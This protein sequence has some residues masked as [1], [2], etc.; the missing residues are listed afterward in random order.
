MASG[1]PP[2]CS[3]AH[4]KLSRPAPP[5]AGSCP[6]ALPA[7]GFFSFVAIASRFLA[8]PVLLFFSK[9]AKRMLR[10]CSKRGGVYWWSQSQDEATGELSAKPDRTAGARQ[11]RL[12][13]ARCSASRRLRVGP[14]AHDR[15]D[16]R[17]RVRPR[18]R[19]PSS[20]AADSPPLPSGGRRAHAHKSRGSCRVRGG[21]AR[22]RLRF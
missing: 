18:T 4:S 3:A 6:E 10:F 13:P 1:T 15:L 17:T 11:N 21:N 8:T 9:A 7:G 19:T 5:P 14:H 2:G 22:R 12:A 16:Q 20:R